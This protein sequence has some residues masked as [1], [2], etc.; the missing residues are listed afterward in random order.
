MY[1][2]R[3]KSILYGITLLGFLLLLFA[4][5]KKPRKDWLIVFLLETLI[6]NFIGN[7]VVANKRLVFPIRLFPKAFQSS[8]LYDNLLL[9]LMCVFYNQTTYHTKLVGMIIQSFLYSIPMTI[10]EV[11]LER[12]TKLI[13]YKKW[14]WS[15]TLFSLSGTFLLSRGLMGFI[16]R[17]SRSQGKEASETGEDHE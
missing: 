14:N 11:I 15:Y 7:I 4:L 9:P 17:W 8:V 5:N 1:K 3:D 12:K 2:I 6:A 16:R 10:I 13:D